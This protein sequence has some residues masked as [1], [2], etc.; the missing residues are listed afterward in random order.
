MAATNTT[1]TEILF[2]EIADLANALDRECY[3]SDHASDR[4]PERVEEQLRR[5]RSA[6]C[7]M[8]WLADRGAQALG[9]REVRGNAEAWLLPPAYHAAAAMASAGMRVKFYVV[10]DTTLEDGRR[11]SGR[12][13]VGPCGSLGEAETELADCLAEFPG[14]YVVKGGPL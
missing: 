11:V 14:A 6:V 10:H 13:I 1:Q 7:H 2:A 3:F 8:G 4:D 9:A 12:P 5:L